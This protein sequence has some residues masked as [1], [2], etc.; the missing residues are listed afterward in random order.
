MASLD[1]AMRRLL[2]L[3]PGCS[4]DLARQALMDAAIEFCERSYALQADE[5]PFVT[6][7]GEGAYELF[8]FEPGV[9]IITLAGVRLDGVDLRPV[10]RSVVRRELSPG[11]PAGYWLEHPQ[12]LALLPAPDDEYKINVRYVLKPQDGSVELPDEL[13]ERWRQAVVY[14]AVVRLYSIPHQPFYN[15]QALVWYSTHFA[16]EIKRAR[17]ELNRSNVRTSLSVNLGATRFA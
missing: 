1:A 4:D 11:R 14:G 15:P 9:E 6:T 16:S 8:S 5:D 7:P 3:V 12:T 13:D 17:I 10:S 2:P